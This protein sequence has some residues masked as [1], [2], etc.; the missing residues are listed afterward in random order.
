MME[1]LNYSG[2]NL[3]NYEPI[4]SDLRTKAKT[5]IFLDLSSNALKLSDLL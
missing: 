5:I 4:D 3:T 1:K 2:Q